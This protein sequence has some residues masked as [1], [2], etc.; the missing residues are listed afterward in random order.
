VSANEK[1]VGGRHYQTTVQCWDYITE[2][3]I[4]YL[5]GNVIKYVS[6][7][8]TKNG[9]EDLKKAKHYLDKIIENASL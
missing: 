4:P 9:I 7:W 8:R 3:E 1:Q 2:N 6:R 5:E